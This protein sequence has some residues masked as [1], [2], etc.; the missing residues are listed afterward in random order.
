MRHKKSLI[1]WLLDK[2]NLSQLIFI[3]AFLWVIAYGTLGCY[4]LRHQFRGINSLHDAFYYTVVTYAT[5]GDNNISPITN[6]SK[7]FV[8]SMIAF[9][10]SSFAMFGSFIIYQVVNRV[11]KI[12]YK[13][14]G[15][16]IK[17]KNH[18][19]LCG[20]SVITELLINKF[21]QNQTPFILLD[22]MQHHELNSEK[23]G[24]FLYVSV[25]NRLESLIKANIEY[26]KMVIASSDLDSENILAAV[27]ADRLKKQFH[28]DFKIV[29]RVLYEEN[30]AVAKQ[31]G[32]TDV[33]SPTLMAANAI[34]DLM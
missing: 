13:I 3:S 7:D 21:I 2:I 22:N 10:L 5:V 19:I 23:E 11:Q 9:G 4:L 25:P 31:N 30:F 29:V 27:N 33:I 14:Q 15:G 12:I 16:K 32:A 20:Y 6:G 18:I 28:A 26:C 8:V 24:N 34:I 1:P 17:M